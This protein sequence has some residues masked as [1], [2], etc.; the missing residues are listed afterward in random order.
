MK[1]R[2]ILISVFLVFLILVCVCILFQTNKKTDPKIPYLKTKIKVMIKNIDEINIYSGH[3]SYTKNKK[4]I[5]LCLYDENGKY[6]DDNTLIYVMLHEIAHYLNKK[7]YGHTA[8]YY[9]I[10]NRL[11][12]DAI[13]HGLYNPS[14]PFVHKYCENDDIFSNIFTNIIDIF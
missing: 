5:Y 6:Y 10:F 11:I 9:T 13:S 3:K 1:Y 8:H 4:D 14:I 12:K 7:D 2:Y